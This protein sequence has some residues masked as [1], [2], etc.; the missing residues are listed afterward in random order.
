VLLNGQE[1][2][3]VEDD[4]FSSAG[5]VGLWTKADSVTWFDD[6]D[7]RVLDSSS[8]SGSAGAGSGE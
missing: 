8:S 4:T 7:V 2:F 5:K 1:L 6:L 3:Q